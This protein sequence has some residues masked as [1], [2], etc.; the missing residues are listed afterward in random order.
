MA[1][2]A[3]QIGGHTTRRITASTMLWSDAGPQWKINGTVGFSAQWPQCLERISLAWNCPG[4]CLV[5]RKAAQ[6]HRHG[7]VCV[8]SMTLAEGACCRTAGSARNLDP[9]RGA[10]DEVLV[11][12]EA[13]V[14]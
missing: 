2:V 14:E 4:V 10:Y 1:D 13:P 3:D 5:T 12:S 8:R 6:N 9:I 11:V 7:F